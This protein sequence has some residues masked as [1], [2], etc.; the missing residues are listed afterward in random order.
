MLR[1]IYGRPESVEA[2]FCN[3]GVNPEYEALIFGRGLRCSGRDLDG[4]PRAFEL[5]GHPFF[6]GTLYVPQ[7]TSSEDAPIR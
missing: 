4:V 5:S 7:L 3:Y 2:F 6:I 1:A